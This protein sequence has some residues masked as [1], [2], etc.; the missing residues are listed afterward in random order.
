[1]AAA[2][3]SEKPNF[4][5]ETNEQAVKRTAARRKSM[6]PAETSA[7]TKPGRRRLVLEGQHQASGNV[8]IYISQ[9]GPAKR[10]KTTL[11]QPTR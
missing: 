6:P 3:S 5:P 2:R 4:L 11:P 9:T 10:A 1:M 8:Y 7:R